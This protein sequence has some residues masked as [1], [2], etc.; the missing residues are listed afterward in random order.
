MQDNKLETGNVTITLPY[1]KGGRILFLHTELGKGEFNGKKL[2][3]I[4][5]G[6]S[7]VLQYYI[8]GNEWESYIIKKDDFIKS[9][10][11]GLLN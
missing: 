11:E 3:V 10:V 7:F 2:R 6:S 9:L 4:D 1:K 5:S 8:K